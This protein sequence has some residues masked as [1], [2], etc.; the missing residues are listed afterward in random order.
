M[1]ITCALVFFSH[2]TPTLSV[3]KNHKSQGFHSLFYRFLQEKIINLL[4]LHQ[5]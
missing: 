4:Y 5:N 2:T 3:D 1:F